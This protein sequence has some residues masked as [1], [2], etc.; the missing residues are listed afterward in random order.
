MSPRGKNSSEPAGIA[1]PRPIELSHDL[2][3]PLR[4]HPSAHTWRA[5]P[6]RAGL[7][8][9][10]RELLFCEPGRDLFSRLRIILTVAARKRWFICR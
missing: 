3:W 9:W 10:L 2:R 6:T 4:L 7:R 5:M 1:D 8:A